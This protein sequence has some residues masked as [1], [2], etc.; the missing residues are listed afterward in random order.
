MGSSCA[1]TVRGYDGAAHMKDMTTATTRPAAFDETKVRRGQPGNDGQFRAW[2][3][4]QPTVNVEAVTPAVLDDLWEGRK[5]AAR[6]VE[7]AT[8]NRAIANIPENIRGIRFIEKDGQLIAAAVIPSTPGGH[9]AGSDFHEHHRPVITAYANNRSEFV[10]LEPTYEKYGR[11]A[12]DWIP[13]AEQRASLATEDTDTAREEALAAF[14]ETNYAYNQASAT[15]LRDNIPEGVE[16]VEVAYGPVKT[17]RGRY[18]TVPTV[19]GMYDKD[20]ELFTKPIAHRDFADYRVNI[21]RTDIAS[22]FPVQYNDA[23]GAVYTIAAG[24]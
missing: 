17:H 8:V 11:E 13:T 23:G 1:V 16:T 9:I 20:G 18:E 3:N 6:A 7:E 2:D 4:A 5:A 15:Y 14:R 21:A 12:W 10:P 22:L 19:I 24:E